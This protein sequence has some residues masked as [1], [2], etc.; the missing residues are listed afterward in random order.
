MVGTPAPAS[1]QHPRTAHARPGTPPSKACE[2]RCRSTNRTP[3]SGAGRA[4]SRRHCQP[5]VARISGL[6]P[7]LLTCLQCNRGAAELRGPVSPD[8]P[9]QLAPER[10]SWSPLSKRLRPGCQ[11]CSRR[12]T[13]PA[14][15][16][17]TTSPSTNRH[18]S[19]RGIP[20]PTTQL[21]PQWTTER[22]PVTFPYRAS[23]HRRQPASQ[24]TTIRHPSVATLSGISAIVPGPVQAIVLSR[25]ATWPLPGPA[26]ARGATSPGNPSSGK[27]AT[28]RSGGSAHDSPTPERRRRKGRCRG[29]R[30]G[31]RPVRGGAPRRCLASAFDSYAP[32]TVGSD[33]DQVTLRLLRVEPER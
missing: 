4:S 25:D 17:T 3:A 16:I 28:C 18:G 29:A 32:L 8:H 6:S 1:V 12:R 9:I 27:G 20:I 22:A 23:R 11:S 2:P 33:A 13:G 24:R 21:F 19:Y 26:L 30:T 7:A 10:A 31:R 5:C 15:E 14:E